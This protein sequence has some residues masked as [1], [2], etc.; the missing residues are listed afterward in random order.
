MSNSFEAFMN[1]LRSGL[2]SDTLISHWPIDVETAFREAP[3]PLDY[4]LP[5]MVAGTVGALI[6]PGGLGKSMLGLQV[7]A[8][9]AGGP[10]LLG[11]GSLPAGRVT[12][13]PAEDP[14]CV[15]HQ[16]LHVLGQHLSP[17]QR[18]CVA[19][20]LTV[21]S[22]TGTTPNLLNR[23]WF[24][25]LKNLAGDS[26]LLILDTLRRFHLAEENS[27]AAM[28]EVIGRMEAIA[29]ETGCSVL[30]LHHTNKNAAFNASGDQQQASRGSSVLVD[31]VRWQ[32][33]LSAMSHAEAEKLGVTDLSRHQYVRFGVSK[34]NYSRQA[35]D[36]WLMRSEGGVLRSVDLQP[37]LSPR[38][39]LRAEI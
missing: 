36:K 7:A 15:L 11:L 13:L 34:C 8:Q 37:R 22:L 28:A 17:E 24:Q 25:A 4:V 23:E 12:Y 20:Q 30:F 19:E 16:R 10:D 5:G 29:S 6:S 2:P 21:M 38:R 32:G 3:K 35:V 14:L 1:Q 33:F 39:R 31:N 9:I 26:R 18:K 27:S